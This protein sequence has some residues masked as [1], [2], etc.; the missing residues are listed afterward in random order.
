MGLL[1]SPSLLSFLPGAWLSVRFCDQP[2][3]L[4]L[5]PMLRHAIHELRSLAREKCLTSWGSFIDE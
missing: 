4:G 1:S 5:E 2:Q 3:S